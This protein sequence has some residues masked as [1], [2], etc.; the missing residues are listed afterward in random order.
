MDI[1]V[2]AA[3]EALGKARQ[4][5]QEGLAFYHKAARETGSE[6]GRQIFL[7]LAEDEAMH[8]RLIQRQIDH[9][10]A[11]KSW[12]E[13]PET[14][15]TKC[16]SSQS[17]FPQGREGLQKVVQSD[18]TDAEALIT[19]LEFEARSYDMYRRE[20]Q[21]VTVNAAREMYEFLAAQERTHFDLLMTN[22]ESM[23]RYGG[24]VR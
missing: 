2:A 10:T 4:L 9:L 7:A 12:G 8:Q 22:Y 16:D 17:I 23:V 14:K 5:E 24:W 3:L 18:T 6:K 11:K 20:A 19:A 15:G 1:R 13:L 21:K